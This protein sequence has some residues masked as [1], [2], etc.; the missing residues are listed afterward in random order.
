[1]IRWHIFL[2]LIFFYVF[3]YFSLLSKVEIYGTTPE[4]LLIVLAYIAFYST[5]G[6]AVLAGIYLGFL[7]DLTTSERF[8]TFSLLFCFI[9]FLLLKLKQETSL[10][11]PLFPI[12]VLFFISFQ[13]DL[14]QTVLVCIRY[15]AEWE[16]FLVSKP[17][18]CACYTAIVSPLI[19]WFLDK[20]A[21]VPSCKR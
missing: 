11:H 14:C 8:G 15:Q 5:P 7:T 6:N 1:M 17:L 12:A 20:I 18:V 19:F 4:I 16:V 9:V 3:I 10:D 21:L 13:Y 2:F